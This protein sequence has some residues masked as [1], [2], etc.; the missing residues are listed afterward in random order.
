MQTQIQEL[1]LSGLSLIGE[2]SVKAQGPAFRAVNP[3]TG[4]KLNTEFYSATN[5]DIDRAA[6]LAESAFPASAVLSGRKR[7]AFLRR[8]ADELAA[9]EGATIIERAH[10]E[11]GL[12][13][14]RLQGELDRTIGQFKLF[15]EVLEEGSWV[16]ARIDEAD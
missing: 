12:P 4:E 6:E 7:A 1:K 16:N 2:E 5:A 10:L 3:A 13:L 15:A 11:S 9:A 14:P 8:I